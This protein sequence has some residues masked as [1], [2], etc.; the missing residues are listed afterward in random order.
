MARIK[1]VKQS[2]K[3]GMEFIR[4]SKVYGFC[5]G[6]NVFDSYRNCITMTW[7]RSNQ[8]EHESS[9]ANGTERLIRRVVPKTLHATERQVAQRMVVVVVIKIWLSIDP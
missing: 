3:S 2:T 1:A 9:H 4:L 8:F 7:T 6:Y 5:C